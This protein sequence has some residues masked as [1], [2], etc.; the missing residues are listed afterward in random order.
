MTPYVFNLGVILVFQ[1][2][3]PFLLMSE[4]VEF[5]SL[6]N[7]LE[8]C[9]DHFTT[10]LHWLGGINKDPTIWL[11]E[12]RPPFKHVFISNMSD[13]LKN[14]TNSDQTTFKAFYSIKCI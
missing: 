4:L 1:Q 2:L 8:L 7:L 5:S 14:L 11:D 3:F 10:C 6:S 12:A 9:S 13:K